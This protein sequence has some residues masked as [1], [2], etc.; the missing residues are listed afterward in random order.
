MCTKNA[1]FDDDFESIGKAAKNLM[2]KIFMKK[3]HKNG[4]VLYFNY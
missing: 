2:R 1:E 4:V 3:C